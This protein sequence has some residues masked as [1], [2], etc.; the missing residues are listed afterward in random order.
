MKTVGMFVNECARLDMQD[1]DLNLA[2]RHNAKSVMQSPKVHLVFA[3]H[4]EC[5]YK[6]A[7]RRDPGGF[8]Q[9]LKN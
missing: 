7:C 8:R 6:Y 1:L 3:N 9:I 2:S 5:M 4:L